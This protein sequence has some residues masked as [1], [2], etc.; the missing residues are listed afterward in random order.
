MREC[1]HRCASCYNVQLGFERVG[2][3]PPNFDTTL[4]RVRNVDQFTAEEVARARAALPQAVE[5]SKQHGM[6]TDEHLVQLGVVRTAHELSAEYKQQEDRPLRNQ[7]A[8]RLMDRRVMID[9]AALAEEKAA[10]AARRHGNKAPAMLKK[11]LEKHYGGGG[12]APSAAGG[13]Q[14]HRHVG[15]AAVLRLRE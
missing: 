9:R 4:Q 3:E 2:L 5:L 6:L 12:C 1:I 10:A 8:R 7:W 15:R 14:F 13:R 11:E